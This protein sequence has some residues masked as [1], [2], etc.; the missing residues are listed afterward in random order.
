MHTG[1]SEWT[2]D[3]LLFDAMMSSAWASIVVWAPGTLEPDMEHDSRKDRQ[4]KISLVQER[5]VLLQTE[6]IRVS[7]TQPR[8]AKR[9]RSASPLVASYART[10]NAERESWACPKHRPRGTL[11]KVPT[12]PHTGCWPPRAS[13]LQQDGLVSARI[14]LV[15][16]LRTL[17][18]SSR[19]HAA[20]CPRYLLRVLSSR[21]PIYVTTSSLRVREPERVARS[22]QGTLDRES[23]LPQEGKEMRV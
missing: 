23:F 17:C 12:P 5:N 16:K 4:F 13:L 21:L 9:K 11:P 3:V 2:G 14:P 15:W 7:L 20:L 6:S 22:F 8:C 10:P 1:T 19:M 18:S